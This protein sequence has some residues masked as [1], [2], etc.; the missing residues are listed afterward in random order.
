MTSTPVKDLNS[1]MNFVG[2]GSL[3]KTGGM[4]RA[5]S[6]GDV[7]SRTQSGAAEGQNKAAVADKSSKVSATD[8]IRAGRERLKSQD[9]AREPE[10]AGE[11]TEEAGDAAE[12]AGKDM[13]KEIAEELGVSEEEVARA[14]EELGI[15]L[16]SLFDPSSLRELVLALGGEGDQ[17]AFLTN[18]TL[19]A[20]LQNILET[21][22]GMKASLAEL[23]GVEPAEMQA[24]L[25]QMIS[26]G[27]QEMGQPAEAEG[28]EIARPQITVEVHSGDD[29]V[30]MSADENGN[31][32]KT[33]EVVS[34]EAEENV[35]KDQ[36]GSRQE[37]G[38]EAG[39]GESENALHNPLMDASL[40]N[41]GQTA[42]VTFEQT[43]PFFSEQTRDIM[44]QIMDYMKFQ[45]KPGMDQ[46]EMQ[47]HPESL[48]TVHIQLS[49]K[50]GEITAQFHVQNEAVKAA[51]E[52]QIATLQ[53][54]FK[55]QGIK[56]EAVQV[57]VE[58][59]GFERNLWQGQGQEEHAASDRNRKSH[60]R[61]NLNDL[62]ID[63]L[64]EENA[65]EE[66]LLAAQMMAANGNTVDYTA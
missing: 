30:K 49:S 12:K 46:L 58:N 17:M 31:A 21:A 28:E 13:I 59:H 26:K 1:L 60:R 7:M 16:Y 50:G 47:L 35:T 40:Q 39:R 62:D 8:R 18:E 3:A 27:G 51:I 29:T 56:V 2:G 23:V 42:E 11:V 36:T 64:L 9:T 32:V 52:S 10:K 57:T 41:N 4:N 34:S 43:T 19:F 38:G 33:L 44:N 14:M 45:L 25:E 20:K 65:S 24:W 53:E 15:S 66:D 5:G 54:S 48:G 63:A 55:E 61:I 37:K 22:E 6:F